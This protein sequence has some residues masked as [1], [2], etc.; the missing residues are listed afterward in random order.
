MRAQ[1]V[2][3]HEDFGT[4]CSQGMLAN[5]AAATPS[6]GVWAV[7][8]VNTGPG[9]GAQEN[10][11]FI[12]ATEAGKLNGFCGE[13]CI[14]T[15][16]L[17]NR[18][19]HISVDLAS[20][21]IDNGAIYSITPTSNT[22]KR[23]F[24]SVDCSL[25]SNITMSFVCFSGE[26]PGSDY[27]EVIYFDGVSWTSLTPLGGPSTCSPN[28]GLWA[29]H[30]AQLPQSANG[31]PNVKVGFRW[32][33]NAGAN[34]SGLSVAIDNIKLSGSLSTGLKDLSQNDNLILFPNPVTNILHVNVKDKSYAHY[35]LMIYD[36]CGQLLI[37]EYNLSD[38]NSIDAESLTSG[39]YFLNLEKDGVQNWR[40]FIKLNN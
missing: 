14:S 17:A 39:I 37:E 38:T 19:L 35:S 1:T 24:I 6:N 33:N 7:Q 27:A 30:I 23:A 31:N 18:S 9:N 10:I 13:S 36:S 12:S 21:N 22:N 40:K 20:P 28:I 4:G 5:G 34:A 25:Y 29:D 26:I 32:Q 8:S 16:S 3:F 2:F 11:W 15:P